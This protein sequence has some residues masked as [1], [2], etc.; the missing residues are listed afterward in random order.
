MDTLYSHPGKLL[1]DHLQR[2]V[3]T[4][5]DIYRD[6]KG[7]NLPY[8]TEDTEQLLKYLLVFHD[9]GKMTPYFQ[10]YLLKKEGYE[11]YKHKGLTNHGL[12]SALIGAYQVSRFFEN[13][14]DSLR[15]WY[16]SLAFVI[17]RK[18]HGNLENL[19][20]ML[21]VNQEDWKKVEQQLQ[22]C[23]S[24]FFNTH[25]S[26][27]IPIY[28]YKL[29]DL[30]DCCDEMDD[31]KW[32]IID[33]SGIE[34]YFYLNFLYS[35]LLFSDKHEAIFTAER[36]IDFSRIK[37]DIVDRFKQGFF[38][39][40]DSP[41]NRTRESI[42]RETVDSLR[43]LDPEA[44]IFSLNVPT[45]CGKTLCSL[46]AALKLRENNRQ[47]II[48]CLP[49]T[50]VIDQNANVFEN[51]LSVDFEDVK[52][53]ILLKHHHLVESRWADDTHEYS[54]DEA[55]FLI[56]TWNS[57][58]V[59]TT[60]W[61]F[62][63]TLFTHKNAHLK[64][65]HHM[66]NSIIILD[67][68]Q[69]IPV[70]YWNL[71]NEALKRFLHLFNSK[72]I[73]VTATMPMI[74]S[75]TRKEILELVPGKENYF[76]NLNR[77]K[78]SVDI[79]KKSIED[80]A[81]ELKSTIKKGKRYLII[82][83]T[84]QSSLDIYRHLKA[85]NPL[86]LSTNIIPKHRLERIDYIKQSKNNADNDTGNIVV[87]TQL[88][89]AGVDIDFDVVY[90]DNAPLDSINQS[91]GRCNRE[92]RMGQA[93]EVIL[94]YLTHN[95][96][97]YS[98]YIYDQLLL[99]TTTDILQ[100][101]ALWLE[102]TFY[103]ISGDYFDRLSKV[104]SQQ[105]SVELM[106]NI[107]QMRYEDAFTGKDAFRLIESSFERENVFVEVDEDAEKIREAYQKIREITDRWQRKNE[108][109]KIKNQFSQYIISISKASLKKNTPPL[110]DEGGF[111]FI[112][113]G[114]LDEY[115]DLE[116]GFKGVGSSSIW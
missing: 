37:P 5:I 38:K 46:N 93:G 95:D 32:D 62:F 109:D 57:E 101:Q 44:R 3:N 79:R 10:A 14:P 110:L 102:N 63:H 11:L 71:L 81:G 89:E 54:G 86:Y 41:L 29:E 35:I 49:F 98:S 45:G 12:I 17:L 88:V 34:N 114:Q 8:A 99:N 90:R 25:F 2:V 111:Y 6:K 78:L 73:L 75:E 64:K 59:V 106:E 107:K 108:F 82:L 42:Y 113:Y 22:Y 104:I 23:R 28:D 51:V 103:D 115:Y 92:N 7:L 66:T 77:I 116:T 4:G 65:F 21:I 76:R 33:E 18:H 50:S 83:N 58:L 68:I 16:T 27:L 24:Q 30:K 69:A 56:E 96:K 80:F 97:L 105:R 74:F 15:L 70:R 52:S 48:Y 20:Y 43:L 26:N 91:A 53:H 19:Q 55:E 67:E 87:S 100:E 47:R 31:C 84:I 1:E 60:F 94:V 9:A 13:R 112:P 85:Y 72:L 40:G 39:T 61:Q 36:K